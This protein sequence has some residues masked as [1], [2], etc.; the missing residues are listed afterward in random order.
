MKKR[1]LGFRDDSVGKFLA[2]KP[3]DKFRFSEPIQRQMCYDG[4]KVETE[5]N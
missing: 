1:N 5:E 4:L 3:E 2:W